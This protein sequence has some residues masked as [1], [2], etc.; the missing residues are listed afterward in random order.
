MPHL[1]AAAAGLLGRRRAHGGGEGAEGDGH[2]AAHGELPG[3]PGERDTGE[4]FWRLTL[5]VVG[6]FDVVPGKLAR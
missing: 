5:G 1:L 3:D 4:S 2:G 6:L